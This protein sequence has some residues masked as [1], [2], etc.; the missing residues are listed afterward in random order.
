M[1]LD[2]QPAYVSFVGSYIGLAN[3]A[4]TMYVRG[5]NFSKAGGTVSVTIGS[6][7]I[8]AL[9]P[10]SDTQVRVNYPALAAGHYPVQIK[11][12]AGLTATDAELVVLS[13]PTLPYQAIAAPGARARLVYDAERET[14]YAVNLPDE[15][16]ET[17]TRVGGIWTA[18]SPYFLP[19]IRDIALAPNGRKLIVLQ[20]AAVNDISLTSGS[21]AATQRTVLTDTSCGQFLDTLS[22]GNAGKAFVIANLGG[23]SGYTPSFTYDI[24][25]YS[26]TQNVY[27]DGYLYNGISAGAADGSKIYAGSNG[28]SPAPE[29]KIYNTLN[30][31]VANAPGVNV[32][33]N[34]VTVSG[35]ASRVILQNTDVYNGSMSITGH[36][37]G[38]LGLVLASRDSSRAYVYRDD[39]TGGGPRLDIYDLNGS[40]TSGA[41]YPLLKT[42]TLAD[43][44]N[45][46]AGNY[47][48]IQ[49][50]ETP[51]GNTVFVSGESRIVVQPVN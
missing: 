13:P 8:A 15:S 32:N 3:Q 46:S 17:Y 27:F 47:F 43:A 18:G 11:N 19:N 10:D 6:T 9:V 26:L 25:D 14:L 28:L 16:I 30:H 4:G 49:M 45:S 40:L 42:V 51:D 24:R 44:P 1:E 34:A 33:L 7:E 21:F 2:Y 39:A 23:C 50:A 31:T 29:V 41:M 5:T 37:P 22:M 48:S 38:P 20:K 36:L 35:N 12:V